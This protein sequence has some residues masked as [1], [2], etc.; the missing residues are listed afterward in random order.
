MIVTKKYE[1]SALISEKIGN[2]GTTIFHLKEHNQK[3][4]NTTNMFAKRVFSSSTIPRAMWSKLHITSM[5]QASRQL[6]SMV[7]LLCISPQLTGTLRT[8]SME[9]SSSSSPCSELEQVPML[10]DPAI[11]Q[12]VMAAVQFPSIFHVSCMRMTSRL[13]F[14]NTQLEL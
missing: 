5:T 1:S 14:N 8:L 6:P 12:S 13:L 3:K 9:L 7:P 2:N 4:A 10:L 11:I